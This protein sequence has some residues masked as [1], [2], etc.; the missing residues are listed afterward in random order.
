MQRLERYAV[1]YNFEE[2]QILEISQQRDKYF[3]KI[4][5]FI[6]KNSGII[7]IF[8]YGYNNLTN[9]STLQSVKNHN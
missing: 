2:N 6:K 8:D 7:I 3:D 1:K 5:K 4:C 9:Y